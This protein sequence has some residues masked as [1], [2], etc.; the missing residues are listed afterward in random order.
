MENAQEHVEITG[1]DLLNLQQE[2]FDNTSYAAAML[3][4]SITAGKK[5]ICAGTSL[6][7][8][9]LE[10]FSHQLNLN[11][12]FSRALISSVVLCTDASQISCL[13]Q[14][15]GIEEGMRLE[16][17]AV[18][19]ANEDSSDSLIIVS[20]NS[21]ESSNYFH[22]MVDAAHKKDIHIVCICTNKDEILQYLSSEND[23]AIKLNTSNED[24]FLVV[25]LT[26]LNSI[27]GSLKEI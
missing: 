7:R 18:S 11:N 25:A 26:L 2:A 4:L 19:E 23:V 1:A 9:L 15:F 21:E 10:I 24:S 5:I 22:S 12:Y 16:F 17:D 14:N 13:Y 3:S 20:Q 27:A 6:T 8:P